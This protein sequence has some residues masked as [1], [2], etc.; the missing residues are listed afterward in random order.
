MKGLKF[1]RYH[2]GTDVLDAV[3]MPGKRIVFSTRTA[4]SVLIDESV[5]QSA[6]HQRFDELEAPLFQVLKEKEFLV[7]ADQDGTDTSGPKAKGI[8]PR[9]NTS[10]P[11]CNP[12]PI[13]SSAVITAG[14]CTPNTTPMKR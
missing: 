10:P 4:T 8:T 14:R 1:S 12:P 11:P 9:L 13:V 6:L 3:G 7:P 2:I 5:Y